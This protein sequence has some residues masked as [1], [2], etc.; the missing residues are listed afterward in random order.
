M[1]TGEGDLTTHEPF[2]GKGK[3]RL[4]TSGYFRF[5]L[6]SCCTEIKQ[7]KAPSRF[8]GG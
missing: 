8:V 3:L 7:Q 4:K 6:N 2:T 5:I 1:I